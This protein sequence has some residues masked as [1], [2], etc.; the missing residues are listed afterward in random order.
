MKRIKLLLL[1]SLSSGTGCLALAGLL[2]GGAAWSY[3]EDSQLFYTYIFGAYG[4]K[5]VLLQAPDDLWTLGNA[6]AGSNLTY[7][8]LVI[9]CGIM[10]GLTTYTILE[11]ISHLRRDTGEVIHN[12]HTYGTAYRQAVRE[13]FLRLALRVVALLSWSVYAIIFFAMLVP[14][15]ILWVQMGIDRIS[16]SAAIL[17]WLT[18][19]GSWLAFSLCLHVNVVFARLVWLRPR[20]FGNDAIE[21]VGD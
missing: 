7:Y 11:A 20:L 8:V 16:M 18:I 2:L 1:P 21:E 19:L 3:I 14:F 6:I 9:M 15:C 12:M 17:G 10:A 4:F 13:S 5:T